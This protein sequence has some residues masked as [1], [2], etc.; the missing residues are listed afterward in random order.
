MDIR[1]E[2]LA[3]Q[4]L[5]TSTLVSQSSPVQ[6]E[7]T[8]IVNII[9]TSGVSSI[10]GTA[11]QVVASASTGAV[12]LSTPQSIAT[13]SSPTFAD[14][15]LSSPTHL[16]YKFPSVTI[17]LNVITWQDVYTVGAGK[18]LIVMGAYL[19]SSSV[20]ITALAGTF[21]LRDSAST[22]LITAASIAADLRTYFFPLLADPSTGAGKVVTAGNK[23]Q[24]RNDT[25]FGSAATV[26]LDLVGYVF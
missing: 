17:D 18:T 14:L 12:T 2:R 4:A 9:G 22:T 23:V 10:T 15:T 25:A 5:P 20:D 3:N 6:V 11:N 24:A 19:R 16:L 13:T 7:R 8:E 26:I 21:T 1:T